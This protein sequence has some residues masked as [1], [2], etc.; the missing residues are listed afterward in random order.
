MSKHTIFL[1][2]H[3]GAVSISQLFF[4]CQSKVQSSRSVLY[5]HVL[6]DSS[7]FP[8]HN[9]SQTHAHRYR[10]PGIG[11]LNFL[12]EGALDGGGI[13][14]TRPDPLGKSF[15]QMLLDMEVEGISPP[16]A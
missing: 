8:H 16:K 1:C 10:L 7:V 15:A 13:A 9:T 14:S 2:P 12:L 5:L 3:A 11:G 4:G 6:Y